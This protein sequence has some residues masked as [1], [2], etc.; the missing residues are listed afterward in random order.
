MKKIIKLKV[1]NTI[2]IL[3][4]MI[5]FT[6]CTGMK[7]DKNIVAG[8]EN[9]EIKIEGNSLLSEE[10]LQETMEES[11][12]ESSEKSHAESLVESSEEVPVE[13]LVETPVEL[14]N[15]SSSVEKV[16]VNTVVEQ[17][18]IQGYD[19]YY[20]LMKDYGEGKL[21]ESYVKDA[22]YSSEV[23]VRYQYSDGTSEIKHPRI[24]EISFGC[25]KAGEYD[26][27]TINSMKKS[28]GIESV[29]IEEK[30]SLE[31]DHHYAIAK[32]K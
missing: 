13:L 14:I 27:F 32:F 18:V 5:N 3:L 8:K 2:L 25:L 23:S 24:I 28:G 7:Q 22:I 4:V 17:L 9:K 29:F 12:E 1:V 11:L 19:S 26:L 31:K 6:A 10:L 20:T 15:Y 30:G 16:P 21:S